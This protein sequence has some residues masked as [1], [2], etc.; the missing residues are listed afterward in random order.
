MAEIEK[1]LSDFQKN[2]CDEIVVEQPVD[3]RLCPS[4]F[5]DPNFSLPDYWFNIKEAYLNEK[6]C[7]YH[8]RVYSSNVKIKSDVKGEILQYGIKKILQI[9]DQGMA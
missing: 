5:P 6:F 2:E 1:K 7:E 8:V 4:C 9:F 3:D